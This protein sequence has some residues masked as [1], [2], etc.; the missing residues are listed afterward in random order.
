MRNELAAMATVRGEL[1]LMR[2]RLGLAAIGLVAASIVSP[3]NAADIRVLSA[4]AVERGLG[5]VAA[6][7][8]RSTGHHVQ[9]EYAAAPAIAARLAAD[10]GFD[11]VIAPPAVLDALAGAGRLGAERVTIG[12]V[13][14]GVAVRTS[15]RTPDIASVDALKRELSSADAVVFNRASTGLYV[16]K[17]LVTLGVAES[18]NARAVRVDD[19]AAVMRRLLAGSASREFGFGA[20]TEIALFEDQ[21]LRLVGPLPAALQNTTTYAASTVQNA[22]VKD[23]VATLMLRLQDTQ[24]RAAFAR[25]GIEPAR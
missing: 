20:M 10:P 1:I 22:A 24:A 3:A 25:A 7:F 16:E 4:G 19:G 5:P 12:K 9:V 8:E 23:A 18:V 11:I 6:D 21:G 13:G 15:A 17:M 2:I 14:I